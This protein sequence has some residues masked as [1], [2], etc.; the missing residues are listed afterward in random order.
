VAITL[1]SGGALAGSALNGGDVTLTFPG[2]VAQNDVVIVFGGHARAAGVTGNVAAL[3]TTG[4]TEL[5]DFSTANGGVAFKAWYKVMGAT[6]DAN[7]VSD[8]T[9][10]A[11]D[12]EAF[13][14]YI[15]RG[16]DTGTVLDATPTVTSGSSTNPD[17]P[18]IVTQT[19]GAW[20][21]P[22]AGSNAADASVT[23]P[24]GYSN[25]VSDDGD[26]TRNFTVGGATL[27]KAVAGSENPPSWT[28]WGNS[29]WRAASVA[30]RPAGAAAAPSGS[31]R[32]V[33]LE[34][35]YLVRAA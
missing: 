21:I 31:G 17:A 11:S 27:E 10:D 25:G 1:V 28:N 12:G 6:P 30:I 7:V 14:C 23:A 34:R 2:G 18:A 19:N 24:S 29:F 32:L 5:A 8:G 22:M 4:Y 13:A 33:G 16:V 20:V 35:N 3:T 26:D 15:L 9:G